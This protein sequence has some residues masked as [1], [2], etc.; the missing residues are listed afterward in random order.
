MLERIKNMFKNLMVYPDRMAQNMGM[1]KGLYHSEAILLSL[2][3]K[4][5]TRQEAYKLTQKV[6]MSCYEQ[7]LNFTAEL[8]KDAD[9]RQYL[10]AEEIAST[11]NNEHYFQHVDTIFKRYSDKDIP[12]PFFF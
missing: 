11:T 12:L 10:T 6:A 4:G 1:S 9:I 2:I 7:G 8:E 3:R 5:L